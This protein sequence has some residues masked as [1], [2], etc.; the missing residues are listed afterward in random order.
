MI[1]AIF[2]WSKAKIKAAL[3]LQATTTP[4]RSVPVESL[5]EDPL[6]AVS[7]IRTKENAAHGH[8]ITTTHP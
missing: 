6:P 1:V 3:D 8:T 4:G 5:Y 2:A 7:A